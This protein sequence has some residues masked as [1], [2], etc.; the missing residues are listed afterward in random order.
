MNIQH[1]INRKVN[2]VKRLTCQV[3]VSKIEELERKEQ[4]LQG[5]KY[6]LSKTGVKL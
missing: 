5:L 1:Q 2:R 3:K 6:E 4:R